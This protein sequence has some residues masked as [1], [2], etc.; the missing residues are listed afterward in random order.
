MSGEDFLRVT[1][2]LLRSETTLAAVRAL[3]GSSE[4][5]AVEGLVELVHR[6]RTAAEAVAALGA[7]EDSTNPIVCAALYPALDSHPP[8]VRL[9]AVEG[10]PR[11]RPSCSNS[12]LG[13]ILREDE[14]WP[15]RRAALHV[16]ASGPAP[17]RWQVLDGTTDPHWRVRHALI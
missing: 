14:S 13:R 17:E 6:H 11:R 8:S 12:S 9:A 3:H 1:H 16:L 15:V 4:R 2:A 5:A 7:L 10:L